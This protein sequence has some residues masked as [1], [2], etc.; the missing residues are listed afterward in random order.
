MSQRTLLQ[1]Y[2]IP[3]SHLDFSYIRDCINVKELERIVKILNSGEEGFYPDLTK[4]AEE[5][6]MSLKPE[7]KI[8]RTDEPALTKNSMDTN[9]W[10][11]MNNELIVIKFIFIL[12]FSLCL[13]IIYV[14]D[15]Y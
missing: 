14:Y 6:L 15:F 13:I 10:Q 8:L 12:L 7:S 5:K 2:D 4:C 11:E 1:K 9:E 3:I